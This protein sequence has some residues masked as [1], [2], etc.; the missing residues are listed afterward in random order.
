MRQAEQQ[1]LRTPLRLWPGV[2]AAVL[3]CVLRYIVPLVVPDGSLIGLIGSLVCALAILIWWLFFSRAA[4]LERFAALALMIGAVFATMPL[5]HKSIATGMMGKMFF[6]YAVP[7]TIT[8]ALVAWAVAT[9]HLS[10]GLR[11]AWLVVALAA[12]CAVWTMFRTDGIMGAGA[13]IAWRWSKTYEERLLAQDRNAP[14]PVA[15]VPNT[16]TLTDEPAAPNATGGADAAARYP[17]EA[18]ASPLTSARESTASNGKPSADASSRTTPSAGVANSATGH[19]TSTADDSSI[20]RVEWPGFRGPRRD[21]V[22]AGI[23]IDKDWSKSPP[24]EMWRRPVGP[25]WSSFAVH[26]GFIYTQEQRGDDEV[27]SSYQLRTGEPVWRHRDGVRFWE[28][29]GGA[30]PRG[31]PTYDKGRLYTFG[32]TGIL[33]A[34]DARTGR[35]V[36]SRNVASDIGKAVPMWGFAS[37]PLVVGN[38]VIVAASGTLVAYDLPTGN[39]RWSGPSHNG[40]YSSPHLSMIDG[41]PQILLLSAAGATSVAPVDGAVLWEYP[42]AGDVT[43]VQPAV[44]SGSDVLVTSAVATGGIGLRRLEIVHT[45]NDWRVEERWSSNGLK[46][47]F[48]DFVVH[49]GYAFGFDGAILSCVDLTDGTRKWKGGRYGNG[50]LVLLPEQDLLLV[51]SEEGDLALVRA[52][53]DQFSEV[54]RFTAL[55]GKTWNHPVLVGDALLV[56]NDHEMAAFRLSLA[57]RVR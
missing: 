17:T 49:N 27:V 3:L 20:T 44:I 18:A 34:L 24:V 25:G 38:L 23:S 13:Q 46:P 12:G 45:G 14:K 43:I 42:W 31:T 4:W 2:I 22:I 15:A 50:Q 29:N 51:I 7:A 56:R 28:S 35:V 52:T 57:N 9:R 6:I 5:L 36:W 21:G 19:G 53:P 33:N 47:Y 32:A 55:E 10:D 54:G 41:V 37:S 26:D 39:R 1:T 40:S 30:G 8:P 48:N 16:A 11:R